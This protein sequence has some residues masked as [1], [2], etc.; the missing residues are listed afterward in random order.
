MIAKLLRALSGEVQHVILRTE[1]QAAGR[2]RLDTGRLEPFT[3]AVA[4]ERALKDAMRLRIHLRNIK[5]AARD[6]VA[7]ADAI[8]LLEVHDAIGVLNDGAVCRTRREAPG[9]GAMHALVLA[10][11][12]H[13][14]AV[15]ALM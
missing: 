12:P 6:A 11:K 14:R 9:L 4:A 15:F 13:R 1:M 5:G 2:T 3:N 8:R 7:A 10:H